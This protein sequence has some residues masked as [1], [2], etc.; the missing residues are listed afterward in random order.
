MVG[1]SEEQGS[2]VWHKV[3]HDSMTKQQ[4]EGYNSKLRGGEK[5]GSHLKSFSGSKQL[6]ELSVSQRWGEGKSPAGRV[7]L[8][9]SI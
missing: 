6:S 1:N 5:G 4:R 2:L 9:A 8:R 3:G 7:R